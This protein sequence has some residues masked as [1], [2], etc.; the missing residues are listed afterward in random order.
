MVGVALSL[1]LLVV[2]LV[3]SPSARDDVEAATHSGRIRLAIIAVLTF[4]YLVVWPT[5]GFVPATALLL[6]ASTAAFGGRG[7]RALVVVPAVMTG[8]LYLLF[9]SLL[10]VPL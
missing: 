7:L 1:A 9:S 3:R 5:A 4:V 10:K 2:A 6:V 8:A